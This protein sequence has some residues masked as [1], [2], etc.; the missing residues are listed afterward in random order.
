[1]SCDL[2][3]VTSVIH[4]GTTPWSYTETR[5]LFSPELRLQQTLETFASIRRFCPGAKIVLVEGG[6]LS[7]AERGVLSSESDWFVD[8]HT[9]E[10]TRQ[11]CLESGKKGLGDVWLLS[12]G[13]DFVRTS[14]P[15]QPRLVFKMSGRYRLN[16]QFNIANISDSVPTFR[17]FSET[18]C[19]TFCFAVPGHMLDTYVQIVKGA[20]AMYCGSQNPSLEYYLPHQFA[21]IQDISCIGAEGQIAVDTSLSMYRV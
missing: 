20:V 12:V 2:F 1:M 15:E 17:R 6:P 14:V 13:L 8:A 19:I 10:G 11:Y 3:I 5:S 7:E 9:K 4:T 18:G 21:Q 16:E